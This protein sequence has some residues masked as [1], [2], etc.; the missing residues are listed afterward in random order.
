MRPYAIRDEA[1]CLASIFLPVALEA[2]PLQSNI[3]AFVRNWVYLG[4]FARQY[5]LLSFYC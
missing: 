1:R 5:M 3:H 4:W 2:V